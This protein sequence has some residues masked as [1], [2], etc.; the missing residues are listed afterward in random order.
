MRKI[1]PIVL[2]VLVVIVLGSTLF[3]RMSQPKIDVVETRIGI[4]EIGDPLNAS[5]SDREMVE[6]GLKEIVILTK[7]FCENIYPK[8][9]FTECVDKVKHAIGRSA[10]PHSE[11]LNQKEFK[12]FEEGS[13]G[14]FGGI[15]IEITR[16]NRAG[17][18]I[19]VVNP[20]PDTPAE[21]AGILSGDVITHIWK[22]ATTKVAT[23]S[24]ASTE[25]ASDLMRGDPATT[26]SIVVLRKGIDRE[27]TFTLLRE[28]IT[29]VQVEG[30]LV[31]FAG[32]TYALIKNKQFQD[33]NAA[34]FERKF[35]ALK[36]KAGGKLD[37]III[38]MESNSGGLLHE[39]YNLIRLFDDS[40]RDVIL[41]RS[42]GGIEPYVPHQSQLLH[43]PPRVIAKGLPV[44]IVVSGGCA[45]A[46]EVVAKSL[47]HRG[48]AVI[49]GTSETYGKGI[50][51]SIARAT[52]GVALKH[53]SS[54]YLI[55]DMSDWVPVQCLGVGL[56]IE[57]AYPNIK[58]PEPLAECEANGHVNTAGPMQNAPIHPRIADGNPLLFQAAEE[59][60]EAYK[61]YMLPKMQKKEAERKALESELEK[62]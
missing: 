54:E 20:I 3:T 41:M 23:S 10:D 12:A 36:Q 11:Y 26:V 24:L 1:L 29:V 8:P 48:I 55:G 21:R 40:P 46:C 32:K 37:G 4:D 14:K 52:G 58:A 30:D 51:Q 43:T 15:G 31:T 25:E 44:L 34:A 18:P 33:E 56:D 47:K 38:G 2:L 16:A 6:R 35:I 27:L 62:K 60:L 22:N 42:N 19:V 13:S 7:F 45:S 17:A 50:V 39:A 28:V 59:M 5:S 61:Q 57:F 49:A 53:T 9:T